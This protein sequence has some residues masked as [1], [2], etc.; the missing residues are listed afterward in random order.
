MKHPVSRI[1]WI[2]TVIALSGVLCGADFASAIEVIRDKDSLSPRISLSLFDNPD[3]N[4]QKIT[5]DSAQDELDIFLNRSGRKKTEELVIFTD[6][7]TVKQAEPIVQTTLGQ[8]K[9]D[10]KLHIR[11]ITQASPSLLFNIRPANMAAAPSSRMMGNR[12]TFSYAPAG[13]VDVSVGSTFLFEPTSIMS[14]LYE[15]LRASSNM[16]RAYNMS[17]DFGY[18]GFQIGASFSQDN[19]LFADSLSGFDI[20]FGYASQNWS[21]RVSFAEYKRERDLLFSSGP[22]YFDRVYA[23]E[24]GADYRVYSNIRFS[25]RFTYYTYGQSGVQ[26]RLDDMQ[27]FLLGTNVDF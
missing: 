19:D 20:G 21:T 27:I 7:R 17:L 13:G 10:P 18:G 3:K 6:P 12:L 9:K 2:A 16:R 4:T 11:H 15:G 26:D 23:L 14:P 8:K 22:D 5:P 25:G 1:S 24:I